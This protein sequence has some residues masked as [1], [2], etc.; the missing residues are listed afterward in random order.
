LVVATVAVSFNKNFAITLSKSS[1]K[2]I[3]IRL[4]ALDTLYFA[5][6]YTLEMDV[7]VYTLIERD[8]VFYSSIGY[9]PMDNA[10]VG[11]SMGIAK[12]ADTVVIVFHKGLYLLFRHWSVAFQQSLDK[13]EPS[14]GF[15]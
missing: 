15:L 8:S 3:T 1:R 11:K 14:G 12:K 13:A 9:D 4:L 6:F 10:G 7:R 5:A 2:F